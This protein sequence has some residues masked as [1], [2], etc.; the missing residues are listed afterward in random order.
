MAKARIFELPETR[1][2]FQLKGIVS[3]MDK[4]NAFKEIK[5]KTGKSMRMLNFGVSY[6]KNA[7][8]YL[9]VQGMAL[10]NV[11]FSKR[12]PETKKTVTEKVSWDQRY[13]F[14]KEGFRLIGNN[15]GVKKI[16]NADGK[17]VNDKKTLTDFDT[18]VEV[19]DNLKDGSSVF[20]RGNLE[21]SS[22][23]TNNGEKRVSTKLKPNQISL[24][25]D[26]DFDAEEYSKQ[27]DFN[28]VIVFTEINKESSDDKDT[29]RFVVSAKV[30]TYST[31]EDVGF[32]IEDSKLAGMFKKKLKPY[33]AI[34]VSGHMVAS[35]QEE[36][37]DDD[38]CWGESDAMTRVSAPVKREF[39]I[40]GATP[41]TIDTE[42]YS[43]DKIAQA[44]AAIRK[45]QRAEND[46]GDTTSNS[47]DGWGE[48]S[49]IDDDDDEAWD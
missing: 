41:S 36:V 8:L 12:D 14:K 19:H 18:C 28:Q 2:Q 11:Y 47:N 38:D 43:E 26:I 37:V 9:N 45:A 42:T 29:G 22:Y 46:F 15:I 6:D 4:D 32:I 31:I 27:N 23:K 17:T 24:C 33:T 48:S 39:I 34:K 25:A 1:G 49:D 44:V 7:T 40:T 3:G 5:T 16:V 10:D 20:T 30:V 13:V 35:V 21:F